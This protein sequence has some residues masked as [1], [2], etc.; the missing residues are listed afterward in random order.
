MRCTL[1]RHCHVHCLRN[2]D[3]KIYLSGIVYTVSVNSE[4]LCL[5]ANNAEGSNDPRHKLIV[6]RTLDSSYSIKTR[7]PFWRAIDES[8]LAFLHQYFRK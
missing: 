7:F 5:D 6:M 1:G 2:R 4:S 8:Q 3:G